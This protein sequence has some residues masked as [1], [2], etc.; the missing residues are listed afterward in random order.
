MKKKFFKNKGI[1]FFST[2]L[3]IFIIFFSIEVF[4]RLLL[5]YLGYPTT[6][7]LANIGVNKYDFLTG[8]YN[9]PFQDKFYKKDSSNKKKGR[10][11]FNQGTDRYGFNLD[12]KR[13]LDK[14]LSKKNSCSYRIFLLG[15][16]TV[17]G[18]NLENLNDPLS[19]RLE[20]ALQNEFKNFQISFEV[21]NT[22]AT[23]F[24]SNQELALFQNRI[25]YSLKPDHVIVL[26]GTND[27]IMPLGKNHYLSNSHY[28]QR[29][30]QDNFIKSEKNVF[31]LFDNFLSRN[32][33]V[34][35]LFK[36]IIEKTTGVIFFEENRDD[37]RDNSNFQN[38]SKK[39]DR[40]FYNIKFFDLLS[41]EKLLVDIFFQP[42]MLPENIK[43]LSSSD[44][45]FYNQLL[46]KDEYYFKGKEYFY[47]LVRKEINNFNK[48]K[49][50]QFFQINDI[51][52][53]L[54]NPENNKN[55]YSDHVHYT[56]V[57]R[58]IISTEILLM[59][60]NKIRNNILNN[61]SDCK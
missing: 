1:Q 16:S 22:G 9:K 11:G 54:D 51:S 48:Q 47:N 5:G 20:N 19:A 40:Y 32:L 26:N 52:N 49:K 34:Y 2:L 3:I 25:L 55:F 14:S 36:K 24:F 23:S 56:S 38:I 10:Y 4:S 60:K 41:N 31:N 61:F 27:Y 8:Y 39:K 57:S 37:F 53:I 44:Q 15:G 12:G 18:K 21:I 59:V 33:S 50:S 42:Q 45:G 28:Y 6:Y 35:F 46:K 13:V 30:F 43:N 17:L 29:E 7:K 58:D